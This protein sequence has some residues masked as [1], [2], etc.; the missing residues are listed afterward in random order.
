M[1]TIEVAPP[2]PGV[3]GPRTPLTPA[4]V[5]GDAAFQAVITAYGTGV[6]TCGATTLTRWAG[7]P[8]EDREGTLVYLRDLDGAQVWSAGH[9]PVRSAPEAYDAIW[10]PGV[11]EI[12]RRDHGIES[13]LE[14]CVDP[15]LP[16][17]VRRVTLHN[18]SRRARRI[19]VT[20]YAEVVL[21]DAAADA[22]HPAYSKLFLQTEW[23]A[24][25]RALLVRRRPR[26][27]DETHPWLVHAM[28]GPGAVQHETDR[29]RFVGR[30]GSLESPRALTGSGRLSGT[31][32]NVLDP[33]VSL[34]RVVRLA[35]G[36]TARVLLLLGAAA[37]RDEAL[38]LVRRPVATAN[39]AFERAAAHAREAHALEGVSAA[40]AA[41]RDAATVAQLQGTT[42]VGGKPHGRH[43][44]LLDSLPRN[45]ESPPEAPRAPARPP[46]R[47]ARPE[48]LRERNAHGAFSADGSEYVI[49]LPHRA[50]AGLLRP[51]APWINV[52]ANESF[53]TLVSETGAGSTW[54]GNSREYRLTPWSNDPLLDPHGE[55]WYVRDEDTGEYW[56]PL[57]GPAP[58]AAGYEVRHGFGY[59][60]CTHASH[61]LE[62]DTTLFV[63][64]EDPLKVVSVA[65]TNLGSRPRRLAVYSYQRLVLGDDPRAAAR[66]LITTWDTDA[67]VLLARRRERDTL[68][69]SSAFAAA[70]LPAGAPRPGFTGDRA[71]FLG[72]RGTVAAPRAVAEGRDL[73]R[74]TG[75]DREP[76]FALR[77]RLDVAA[78]AT[79][80]VTFL[81]GEARD[82]AAAWAL[83]RRYRAPGAIDA[84]LAEVR[85]F[86]A[87]LVS[88]VRI[89][90]PRP[91]IDLM[92]NGWLA[93][94]TLA[95][96]IWARSAFYQS[97]GAYGF[98]DQLQDAMS[99]TM[100]APELA[101][102]Q[103]LLHAGHQFAQGDVL[104]W[105]HPPSD[106][107]LRTRF[108]DDLL[109]LP[110]LAMN[111]VDQT[112][113][114]SVL[115]ESAPFLRARQLEP[116]ED[117]A[118]L[119]PTDAGRAG[120]VYE[121]CCRA[122]DRS[123]ATGAHG[124]PLFGTGDWNDGMNRVGREGRGESVWMG[125]FLHAVLGGFIPACERRGDT[126][127]AAR[128]AQHRA[129]LVAALESGGWDGGWYRRGYY[130]DGTPL[131]S[132]TGDECRID[133]LAQAWSVISGAV[134]PARAGRAMDAVEKLLVSEAEGLIRLLTPPFEHTPHDPGYIKGYVPGVRENGGQYTHAALWV[135]RALA[136]LGRR[137]RAAPLL[138]MLSPVTHTRTPARIA[139]YRV[140]P[141]VIAADVYG[142]APHVGRGGWTWYTGSAGWMLR[143]TIESVLGVTWHGGD[144][145]VI[146]PR[147]PDDWP[148]YELDWRVPGTAGRYEVRVER[149]GKRA[150]R[151]VSASLDG[152]ALDVAEDGVSVPVLRDGEVHRV[153]VV[154][155]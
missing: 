122:I 46:R 45:Y 39:A 154:L 29:E 125:F 126:A 49:R 25:E 91:A 23:A 85:A 80:V 35:P 127:R 114:W 84:A 146:A 61:G 57:P 117:E 108:V 65:I 116:G 58:A 147:I 67:G 134:P 63:P 10:R 2:S 132:K 93:Y 6:T 135:V 119:E 149:R 55:A 82:P 102:G 71:S 81:L 89:S 52:L 34:R 13:R 24:A 72:T 36:G 96:R 33:V 31:V 138:E 145:L 75:T 107:G 70:V 153:D 74:A 8:I 4:A 37:G 87:E 50:R 41:R 105:W 152:E 43:A 21:H 73:D 139:N 115:D 56:S 78:G 110:Y 130:D 18:R 1:S 3:T 97:G 99:L 113:D 120:I 59:T 98:R 42:P 38:A 77:A 27:P 144:T 104:H 79:G 83:A 112:G 51:P 11:F 142:A 143:V 17:E 123:L 100:W 76:C 48:Q 155:G 111:Y 148:G 69:A 88:G 94:Q 16:L 5:L 68:P 151:V 32:G 20:S 101:R 44:S 22:A 60:R 12:A 90:T 47:A 40:E 62:H 109:W 26:S 28:P 137:D 150:G 30:G 141:Y 103:V 86:W 133:A 19:E 140:E 136:E 128:Y 121:H 118:L 66:T 53:G 14:V 64:R 9:E 129:K 95:C 54:S 15:G 124:L 92:A 7:D 106:R 131:G